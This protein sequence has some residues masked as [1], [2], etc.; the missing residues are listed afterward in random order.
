VEEPRRF[1]IVKQLEG[2]SKRRIACQGEKTSSLTSLLLSI[3][4]LALF[5]WELPAVQAVKNVGLKD[6]ES[7]Y[8]VW[9]D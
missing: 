4:F 3:L 9:D 5:V 2:C 7:D 8:P 6:F 1:A